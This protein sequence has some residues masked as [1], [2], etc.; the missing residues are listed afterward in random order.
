MA[1]C[2]RRH[3]ITSSKNYKASPLSPFSSLYLFHILDIMSYQ[4]LAYIAYENFVTALMQNGSCC[5]SHMQPIK[6]MNFRLDLRIQCLIFN[7]ECWQSKGCTVGSWLCNLFIAAYL[8]IVTI[9]KIS[10]EEFVFVA[11]L[12]TKTYEH[13]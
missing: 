9:R 1:W 10:L 12:N 13:S 3:C 4:Y 2:M 11:K 8:H 7:I 5:L 6:N